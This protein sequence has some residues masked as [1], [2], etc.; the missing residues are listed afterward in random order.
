M[1]IALLGFLHILLLNHAFSQKSNLISFNFEQKLLNINPVI[2][3][4][5]QKYSYEIDYKISNCHL[6][7]CIIN[8]KFSWFAGLSFMKTNYEIPDRITHYNYILYAYDDFFNI[9]PA[10]TIYQTYED[11]A[12]YIASSIH[13]G[14]NNELIYNF[15]FL[16]QKQKINHAAGIKNEIYF[17]ERFK[18]SFVTTDVTTTSNE[19]II[20]QTNNPHPNSSF[21][22]K[23]FHFSNTNLSAFYQIR[24]FPHDAFSIGL[25]LSAG[26]NLYSDWDKFK[27]YGWLSAGLE[28]GFLAKKNKQTA[29]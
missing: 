17:F 12:D 26:A 10:D 16:D 19:N 22:N 7:Y 20:N 8:R 21:R 24:W 25:R 9:Y 4:A 13:L 29:P 6:D 27:K 15:G 2:R 1:K 3:E 14:I 11:P 18:H 23:T 5:E 28:V